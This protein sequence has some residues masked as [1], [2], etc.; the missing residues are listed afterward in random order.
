MKQTLFLVVTGSSTAELYSTRKGSR[1]ER[2]T[3]HYK[4]R[5]SFWRHLIR[6]K[7]KVRMIDVHSL[8]KCL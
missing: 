1:K 5:V 4:V 8:W 6:Q 2:N 7:V 3:L